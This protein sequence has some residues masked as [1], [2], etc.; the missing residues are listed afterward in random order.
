MYACCCK[1]HDVQYCVE[2]GSARVGE[3]ADNRVRD[4]VLVRVGVSAPKDECERRIRA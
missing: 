1:G 2:R 4:V 3:E